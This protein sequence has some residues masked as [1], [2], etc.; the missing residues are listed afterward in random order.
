VKFFGKIIIVLLFGLG[1]STAILGQE[2]GIQPVEGHWEFFLMPESQIWI[3]GNSTFHPFSAKAEAFEAKIVLNSAKKE[4]DGRQSGQL[5]R[6]FIQER[7]MAQFDVKVRVESLKSGNRDLDN[8]LYN[9]MKRKDYP[10]IR[11][12]MDQYLSP[13]N[14]K[15]GTFNIEVTGQ[16]QIAGVTKTISLTSMVV[17][18]DDWIHLKGQKAIL[19]TDFGMTPPSFFFVMNTGNKIQVSFDLKLGLRRGDSSSVSNEGSVILVQK[20]IQIVLN[21]ERN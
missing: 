17:V 7:S 21:S 2:S 13:E 18:K 3:D 14:E 8:N 4:T 9:V 20:K 15:S 10:E 19:M 1:L 11:F 16:L 5:A 6:A 12:S